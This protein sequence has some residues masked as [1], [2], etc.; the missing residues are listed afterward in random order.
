[1]E[2]SDDAIIGERLD[3]TVVAWNPSAESIYGYTADEMIGQS[4][5]LLSP[6]DQPDEILGILKRLVQGEKIDHFET[7]RRTKEGRII[8]VSL[9]IS[10][11][12]DA[13]G[14]II[15]ASTIARDIT[16][17][18]QAEQRLRESSE[19]YRTLVETVPHGIEEIDTS[20]MITFANTAHHKIYEYGD[21]ELIGMSILDLVARDSEQE[22]LRKY[23]KY[24]VKDQPPPTSYFG[25]KRTKTGKVI[26]VQ[27]AWNYKRNA[28]GEVTGFISVITDITERKQMERLIVGRMTD[29]L[30]RIGRDLHDNLAQ[31]LAGIAMMASSLEKKLKALSSPFATNADDLVKEIQTAGNNVRAMIK[32]VHPVEITPDSLDVELSALAASVRE[33]HGVDCVYECGS[34]IPIGDAESATHLY[35]IASEAIHN[36]VRHARPNQIVISLEQGETT[37]TLRVRDDGIGLSNVVHSTGVGIRIMKYRA[38]LIGARLIIESAPEGG[39]LVTCTRGRSSLV[40]KES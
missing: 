1:M 37:L 10:P 15:G 19:R 30:Q 23:F 40:K 16:Q 27:V 24:L 20:G 11:I 26:D 13:S 17:R 12:R 9:S 31:Q 29:R 4:I 25:Q 2:S 38:D 22:E 8:N 28:Q 6:P 5:A 34:E 33:L 14:T 39:V 3:G 18:K 36:A 7:V 21:G 32:G 35:Y